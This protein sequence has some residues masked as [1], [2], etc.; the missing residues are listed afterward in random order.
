VNLTDIPQIPGPSGVIF[1]LIKAVRGEF[2]SQTTLVWS[3]VV[4]LLG[5]RAATHCFAFIE[6]YRSPRGPRL[7][8][9]S[10]S[11]WG[12][13]RPQLGDQHE[14]FLEHLPPHADLARISAS[15]CRR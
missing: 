3:Q 14:D 2:R 13:R 9:P 12:G 7:S 6:S 1:R 11:Y 5:S 4:G 10:P 8:T 15:T